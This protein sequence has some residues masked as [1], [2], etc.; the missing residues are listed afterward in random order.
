MGMYSQEL[1]AYPIDFTAVDECADAYVRL[2]MH[3]YVNNIYN[4]YNPNVVY[5][6]NLCNKMW[7]KVKRVP[8]EVFEKHLKERIQDKEIAVLSFYNAIASSS[9]NVPMSNEFTVNELKKLGFKWSKINL[10]YLN[11]IKTL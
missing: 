2:S 8:R 10:R 11:Y 1:A 5:L 6:E 4:L 7:M 9:K 3:N